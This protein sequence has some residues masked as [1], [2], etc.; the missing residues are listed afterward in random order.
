MKLYRKTLAANCTD[1]DLT[2]YKQKRNMFNTLKNQLKMEFYQSRCISYKQNAKKLWSLINNTI[3]KVKHKESIIPY[4]TVDGLKQYHLK[5]IA[6]SFGEF[7][8]S[9]GPCSVKKIVP[10]TTPIST[11]LWNIPI[12]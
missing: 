1:E 10:G 3:N 5:T 2:R 8:S 7:Y 4:I 11:Y 6:N 9:L 12:I